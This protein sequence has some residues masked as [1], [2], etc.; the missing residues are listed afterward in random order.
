MPGVLYE[1]V[2]EVSERLVLDPEGMSKK[3]LQRVGCERHG[4][5]L[6]YAGCSGHMHLGVVLCDDDLTASLRRPPTTALNSPSVR[7][8]FLLLFP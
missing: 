1:E 2:V 4:P 6:L 5:I 7:L 8:S 3:E